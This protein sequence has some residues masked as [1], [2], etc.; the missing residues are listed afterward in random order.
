MKIPLPVFYVAVG[1]FLGS[2]SRFLVFEWLYNP[3]DTFFVNV[4]GS[5]LL[6]LLIYYFEY[7]GSSYSQLKLFLGIGF[8]GS[9]TTFSTFI[10]QTVTMN[11]LLA[12]ANVAGNIGIAMF[13]VYLA[14]TGSFL[15]QRRVW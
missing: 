3:I 5:F 9:F 6:G 14:R 10:M 7:T 8:M 2:V 11:P 4:A 13:V 1:G 15:Y 12:M